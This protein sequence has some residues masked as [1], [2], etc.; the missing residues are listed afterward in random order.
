MEILIGIIFIFVNV[1]GETGAT[2]MQS[3]CRNTELIDGV[4]VNCS[5]LQLQS[6]PDFC[7]KNNPEI[8]LSIP[9]NKIINLDLSNN[10]ITR[11]AQNPFHCL[12]NLRVLNLENNDIKFSSYNESLF[13]SLVSLHQLNL[14]RN[15]DGFVNDKV[16]GKLLNLEVLRMDDSSGNEFGEPFSLLTSLHTLDLSGITGKCHLRHIKKITFENLI[17][18]KVLDLSSCMIKY[19]DNGSFSMLQNLTE[20]Y[21]SYNHELGFEP[22]QNITFNLKNTKIETLHLDN[23]RCFM[24]PG[25]TLCREH[26]GELSQ[27]SLKELNLAGNRLEWMEMGVLN[28]LPKSLEKLSLAYNKLSTGMYAFEYRL[29]TSLKELDLSHQL[30]PPSIVSKIFQSCNENQDKH[31]CS[32]E[33]VSN[34]FI[35]SERLEKKSDLLITFYMPPKLEVM[36]WESSRLYGSLLKMGIKAMSLRSIYMKNNIWYNWIGPLYGFENVTTVDLSMNF[37]NNIS[38]EFLTYFTNIRNFNMSGNYLGKSLSLDHSGLTFRNQLNLEVLDLSNNGIYIL[39]NGIFANAANITHLILKENRLYKWD[40]KIDHMRKL[41]FLDLSDNRLTRFESPAMQNLED[42]F[43]YG[44]KNLTVD[45]TNNGLSCTCSDIKFL[46]WLRS[47]KSNFK[48]FGNYTCLEDSSPLHLSL[49]LLMTSCKSFLVWYIVG[50]VS[51]SLVISLSFSY[52]IYR[53]RWKIRYLRYIAN[54]SLRGYHRL[55]SSCSEGF[56]FDAYVSYSIKD[57][58]FVKNEM[59]PN[60]E[61]R[62]DMKLA[63]MHRDDLAGEIQTTN[64]MDCISRSKRTVCVV[65]KNYLES[66]WQDYELNMARMEG[67]SARKTLNFVF[68]ILMPDVCQSKYPRKARDFIKKGYFLEYPDDPVGKRVFWETLRNEIKKDVV[69]ASNI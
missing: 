7:K 57:L 50:S 36:H 48:N 25:T 63:I 20:L 58:A 62:S 37:C 23:I 34:P 8:D 51:C 15:R 28:G 56:E 24:G 44:N 55:Q 60:I 64:I 14:K 67:I 39:H 1:K 12:Y 45:L 68:L 27:T 47:F 18:L 53:N 31:S 26:L 16:F 2:H 11:I 32:T 66:D 46:L 43:N 54:K 41:V 13:S 3:K 40:V 65:S 21:L 49:N 38:T 19:I 30:N 9:P 42:L 17:H 22:L 35:K 4:S 6:I 10:A 69:P 33:H 29:L 52:L 59:I 5:G 61:E